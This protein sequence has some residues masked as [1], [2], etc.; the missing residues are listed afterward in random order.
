[1]SRMAWLR[2]RAGLVAGVVADGDGEGALL[3]KR[4]DVGGSF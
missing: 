2:A 1:M 4:G 3:V